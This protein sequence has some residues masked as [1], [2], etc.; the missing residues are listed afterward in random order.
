VSAGTPAEFP[1][2]TAADAPGRPAAADPDQPDSPGRLG[3]PAPLGPLRDDRLYLGWQY[4]LL[5]PHPGPSPRR[6]TPPAREQLNPGWVAA[7]RREQRRLDRPLEVLLGAGVVLAAGLAAL[8]VL[9]LLNPALT[10]VGML[11]GLAAAAWAGRQIRGSERTMRTRV[12]AERRRV[13]NIAA[14]QEARLF[15]WQA[16]HAEQSRDWQARRTAYDQQKH[17]YAVSLGRDVDRI[18]VAG[19]T[20]A[21]WSA[22]LT[23]IGLPRLQAGG[24][25]T[26]VDLTDGPVGHDLLAVARQAG[27]D[28]LVWVLPDDLPRLDLGAGLDPAALADLLT[29]VASGPA[30]DQHPAGTRFRDHAILDRILGVLG[31][32]PTVA[33]VSAALRV[34]GHIGD[35][36]EDA[37]RGLLTARQI[38]KLTTMFGRGADQLVVERAWALESQLRALDEVGTGPAP[39]TR[40]RLRVVA[41]GRAAGAAGHPVLGNYVA[42][43]LTQVV[44]QSPP[45]EPWRHTVVLLGAEQLPDEILD[46]LADA[47]ETTGTGLVLAYRSIPAPVRDRLGRGHAVVAFMRLGNAA[48]AK[49]ASEQIGT[50]HRFVLAQLTDTV[51]TSVGDTTGDSYTSTLGTSESQSSSS[52]VSR[53]TGRSRGRGASRSSFLPLDPGTSSRSRDHS[54]SSGSSDSESITAGISEST[55]WGVSTSRAVTDSDSRARTVQRSREFLV[56]PHELQQLPPSAMIVTYSGPDGRRVV[57]ADA[58]PGIFGLPTATLRPLE[59]ARRASRDEGATALSGPVRPAAPAPRPSQDVSWRD[60]EGEAQLPPNLGP[61]P[62]RLDWRRRDSD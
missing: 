35:P 7:Q 61:P 36:R 10:T 49:A 43:A 2:V 44:R 32:R 58:N 41:A 62:E 4:A 28:P 20:L 39:D 60:T 48:D 53:T 18:D 45:A 54:E 50:E 15:E 13:A 14:L 42:A 27:L 8:G 37:Q 25:V 5:H 23:M 59:D 57:V 46:G 31:G 6:P 24:E 29:Q 30:D 33:Q 40:S 51:G 38:D 11:A 34:L 9:G 22:L 16:R 56:E 55:A 26:V 3:A 21:G 17:W 52:S 1:A 47:C 12:A 19:G